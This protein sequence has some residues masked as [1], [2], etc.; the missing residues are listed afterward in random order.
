MAEELLSLTD[1]EGTL[2]ALVVRAGPITAYEIGQVYARSPVSSFNTSKGKLY[3]AIRR[4]RERGLI[5]AA[6]VEGDARG[7]ERLTATPAAREAVRR[8]CLEIRPPHLLLEDPLRTKLQSL[9]L[10]SQEERVRWCV[11][12]KAALAERLRQVEAY[13]EEVEAP[14]LDLLHEGAT[15]AIRARIEWLDRVLERVVLGARHGGAGRPVRPAQ[16]PP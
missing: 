9:D 6:P 3:P 2:L 4:L 1:G 15:G 16:P 8:W 12:A 14:F 11:S 13:R 5:E 7:T 10:L